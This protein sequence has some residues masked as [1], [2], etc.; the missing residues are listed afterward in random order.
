[1]I[2]KSVFFVAVQHVMKISFNV[3]QA[4]VSM[5]HGFVTV[6]ITVETSLTNETAV[7]DASIYCIFKSLK[8]FKYV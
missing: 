2:R 6:P 7:S 1:V 3:T 8:R 5:R 4:V